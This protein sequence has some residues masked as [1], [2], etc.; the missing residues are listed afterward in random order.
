MSVVSDLKGWHGTRADNGESIE[1]KAPYKPG[2]IL[3]SR[4][5]WRELIVRDKDSDQEAT[6]IE[7]AADKPA[8]VYEVDGDGFHVF[9]KN[10]TEKMIPWRP[11][12]HMPKEH[13]RI[14]ERVVSVSAERLQDITPGDAVD[15]GIE[16]DNVDAEMLNGGELV[17]DFRNYL[18]RDD[19]TYEDYH[20]PTYASCIDSF[21]S[22]WD[23]VYGKEE[24]AWKHN[25]FVWRIE[26][27][28]LS[29][30]GRPTNL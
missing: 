27:E 9:N 8:L 3:Y 28:I 18:W 23:S 2:D 21:H 14:W 15:E 6:I 12:I 30:T 26:T 1:F 17:A 5:T 10:G 16:Y 29:T 20:F 24:F 19:P 4:E 11:S 13:A 22:L 7:Y 25:P